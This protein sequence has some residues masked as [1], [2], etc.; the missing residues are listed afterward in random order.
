M[1]N[2]FSSDVFAL[3]KDESFDS[4]INQIYQSF[5]GAELYPSLEEKAAG[6]YISP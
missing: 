1:R 3:P 6:C 4:S 2:E 5:N